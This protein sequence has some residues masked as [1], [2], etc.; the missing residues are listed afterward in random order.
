MR[1]FVHFYDIGQGR[2]ARLPVRWLQR[3]AAGRTLQATG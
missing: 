3:T 2:D 1:I